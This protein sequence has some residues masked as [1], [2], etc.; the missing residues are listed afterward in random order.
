[1]HGPLSRLPFCDPTARAETMPRLGLIDKEDHKTNGLCEL[2]SNI[3]DLF[4][5][6]LICKK[7][8]ALLFVSLNSLHEEDAC[9]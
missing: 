3:I 4:N 2:R 6:I 7:S 9:K 5:L 8:V 1:M